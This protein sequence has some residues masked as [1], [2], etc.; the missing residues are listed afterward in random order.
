[1]STYELTAAMGNGRICMPLRGRE[2]AMTVQLVETPDVQPGWEVVYRIRALE[3]GGR[4]VAVADL[5][6][7]RKKHYED[8]RRL[9]AAIRWVAGNRRSEHPSRARK[10]ARGEDVYEMKGGPS[11]LFFNAPNEAIVICTH[12][13]W[14]AKPSKKEQDAE[15]RRCARFRK[16]YLAQGPQASRPRRGIES[17]DRR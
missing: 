12:H 15:F 6:D 13:Y 2:Y 5:L 7:L 4:A 11:R 16:L 17:Y 10:D 8:Y 14:K 3:V 1:M 9:L